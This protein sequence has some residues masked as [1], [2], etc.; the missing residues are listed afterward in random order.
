MPYPNEHAARVIDPSKFKK[1]SFR[2]KDLGDG[3]SL[4]LGKLE[5]ESSMTVQAYR[6]DKE[7][8]TPE[9][10]KKWL[11]DNEVSYISFEPASE[12]SKESMPHLI[13]GAVKALGLNIA[14]KERANLG[15]AL[16]A[17]LHTMIVAAVDEIFATGQVSRAEK[18]VLDSAVAE[19][20]ALFSSKVES[21]APDLLTRRPWDEYV[22]TPPETPMQESL[23]FREEFTPLL[24]RAVQPNGV[25]PIKIIQ[26]GWGSSGYY[27]PSVLQRDGPKIFTKG[28]QMFWDHPTEAEEA[29]RPEGSLRNLAAEFV[30]DAKWIQDHPHGAG[31]YADAKVFEGFRAAVE[32]MAPNIG[33]SIRAEGSKHMGK[34]EGRDGPIIS[35]ITGRRSVDFVTAPGAGGQIISLFEARRSQVAPSVLKETS[36]TDN[37]VKPEEL[38]ARIAALEESARKANADS[39]TRLQQMQSKLVFSEAEAFILKAL[40]GEDLPQ[41]MKERIIKSAKSDLPIKEGSLDCATLATRIKEAIAFERVYLTKVAGSGIV[42]MGE[43]LSESSDNTDATH[44]ALVESF[45]AFGMSKEAAQIA[46]AGR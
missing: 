11:K 32:E 3:V 9:Q 18:T 40:E 13:K 12:R 7:K 25:V 22:E 28:T 29:A 33:V 24:E 30:T 37:P 34:A 10:A 17:R 8:F 4:I 26:P 31:L 19:A 39:D 6:F 41:P 2:R 42:G 44:A 1:D 27:P 45:V 16:E 21:G 5:G 15:H 20:V 46:A 38:L 43:S 35:A 14:L 36:M 23:E